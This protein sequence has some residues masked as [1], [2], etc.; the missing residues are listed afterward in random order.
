MTIYSLY[1]YDRHAHFP[2]CIAPA[3]PRPRSQT[4]QLCVLPR[5]APRQEAPHSRRG[6]PPPRRLCRRLPK[7]RRA[8][9]RRERRRPVVDSAQHAQLRD[10]RRR[11]RQRGRAAH[12]AAPAARALAAPAAVAG[13]ATA[14]CDADLRRGGETC[15]WRRPLT[16]EPRQ[17]AL[18]EVR[19]PFSSLPLHR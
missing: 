13:A 5:L 6:R 1:I 14:E 3:D 18:R 4:L 7:A 9:R 10:R 15:V 2:V 19:P 12:P 11:R 8:C 16:A 17:E